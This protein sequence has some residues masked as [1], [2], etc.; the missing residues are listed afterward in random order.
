LLKQKHL[1]K[2]KQQQAFA[3]FCLSKTKA[4]L[5]MQ[6]HAK[7]GFAQL[8]F[9]WFCLSKTKQ[10]QAKQL[11]KAITFYFIRKSVLTGIL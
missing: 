11:K 8:R 7:L 5:S 1:L 6:N 10:K 4:P 9:A 3:W 2:Q